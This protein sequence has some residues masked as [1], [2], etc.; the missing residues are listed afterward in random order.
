[1][2]AGLGLGRIEDE[3]CFAI[4]LQDGIVAVYGNL[5]EGL[6]AVAK[7]DGVNGIGEKCSADHSKDPD[8]NQS[9]CNTPER[10]SEERTHGV[11]LYRLQSS[12]AR[13]AV[14]SGFLT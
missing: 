11:Q 1:M 10:S 13:R 6:G 5:S 2:D 12:F 9:T 8:K 3:F 7:Y 4:F 14:K